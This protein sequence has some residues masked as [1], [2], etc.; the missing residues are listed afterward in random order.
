VPVEGT[1]TAPGNTVSLA[2]GTE[3][4]ANL[5]EAR[6]PRIVTEA[7]RQATPH[8]PQDTLSAAADASPQ[9]IL[10]RE[11]RTLRAISDEDIFDNGAG[12]QYNGNGQTGSHSQYE[13]R[14]PPRHG[15]APDL[16]A[17]AENAAQTKD[18]LADRGI[19]HA[20]DAMKSMY[21]MAT[22]ELRHLRAIMTRSG[23]CYR[24]MS[25]GSTSGCS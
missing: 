12:N 18:S 23:S 2:A 3:D 8:A 1:V 6:T 9:A 7:P 24:C 13:D 14:T 11:A 16:S 21:D 5:G 4:A 17:R 20:S 25:C 15:I 10:Q 22:R 19:Y